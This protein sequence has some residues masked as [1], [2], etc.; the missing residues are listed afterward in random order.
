MLRWNLIDALLPVK[1]VKPMPNN[2]VQSICVA[3][4]IWLE[5]FL[6]SRTGAQEAVERISTTHQFHK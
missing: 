4:E 1:L 2:I 3:A 6:K 5:G